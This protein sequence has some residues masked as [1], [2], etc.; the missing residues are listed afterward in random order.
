[1]LL[2]LLQFAKL[3]DG[4]LNPVAQKAQR[5]VP[6]PDGLDLDSWI[7]D[8]W[9]SSADESSDDSDVE[10]T[11]G[12][13]VHR[14]H[15]GGGGGG[16]EQMF[17]NAD[18]A[19]PTEKRKSKKVDAH[20]LTPQQIEAKRKQ[21]EAEIE[22]NPYYVKGSAQQPKRPKKFG[23]VIEKV[24]EAADIQSPLEIPGV[25]G[26]HRY[27]EQQD[28]T[29]SWKKANEEKTTKKAKKGKKGKKSKRRT[30]STSS[31]EEDAISHKVNRADGEMP[32]GARST[33]DED[34]TNQT[35]NEFKALDIDL[36]APL[37]P[38]EVVKA[39][40]AYSRTYPSKPGPLVPRPPTTFE[41][42]PPTAY[43]APEVGGVEKAKT[44]KKKTT[45]TSKKVTK[46]EK[47]GP[48]EKKIKKKKS[49]KDS[50]IMQNQSTSSKSNLFNMDDWL[51]EKAT[52]EKKTK[53]SRKSREAY[54]ET[55]GVCTPSIPVQN[56][57]DEF[58]RLGGNKTIS[59]AILP[60]ASTDAME[61][62][63]VTIL[64][65]VQNLGSARLERV[66]L[67]MVD[68]LS[69]NV[70]KS[71][72]DALALCSSL[73][74]HAGVDTS[75]EIRVQSIGAS[76]T[77]RGTV[78]YFIVDDGG[79]VV[80]EK[81]DVRLNLSP[82]TFV[83]ASTIR[84]D[85][86][87]ALLASDDVDFASSS[88]VST[89]KELKHVLASVSK[90]AHFTI[91]EETPKAASLFGR[92]IDGRPICLLIK[93]ITSGIQIDGKAGDESLIQSVVQCVAEMCAKL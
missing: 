32:E 55:S 69:A 28:S 27:M 23:N 38:D 77:M 21:R 7:G 35:I 76:H 34:S 19:A 48:S 75:F 83:I 91:V 11:F 3:Y 90:R 54:E 30:T 12:Q 22:N 5:K 17:E 9:V 53:K 70:L 40:Q 67:S 57:V 66:E 68:T 13:P 58:T 18:E 51:D 81:L 62:G 2:L 85:D 88:Q 1:M 49:A 36:D 25:V 74:A 37:R 45:T 87:S 82:T 56:V 24:E 89:D 39:P 8:E 46:T 72:R 6:I 65:N 61:Q 50:L 71:D 20:E 14:P 59:L 43:N 52:S 33:D 26:L 79:G 42:K 41:P 84:T 4:E 92:L 64:V 63:R 86:Y 29:L 10:A 93:K 78:T 60:R 31:E 16:D 44:K 47:E 80:E 73:D 15:I